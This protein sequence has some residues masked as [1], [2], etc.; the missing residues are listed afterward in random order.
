MEEVKQG[1]R[2]L[3]ELITFQMGLQIPCCIYVQIR[4]KGRVTGWAFADP[5]LWEGKAGPFLRTRGP[6]GCWIILMDFPEWR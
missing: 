3:S 4:H 2:R 6:L 1:Y 5:R